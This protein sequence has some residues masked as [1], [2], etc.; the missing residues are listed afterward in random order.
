MFC[1]CQSLRASVPR[2]HVTSFA[3]EPR[4]SNVSGFRSPIRTL[5]RIAVALLRAMAFGYGGGL[6]G[7]ASSTFKV[8]KP[9]RDNPIVCI[10]E[11]LNERD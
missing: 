10:A 3:N 7:L 2:Q 6:G 5:R 9:E 1:A 8:G 11:R 4:C